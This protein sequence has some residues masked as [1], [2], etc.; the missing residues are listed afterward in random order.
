MI[1]RIMIDPNVRVR[2]NGTY[3]GFEDVRGPVSVGMDVQVYE[4]EAGI[5]GNGRVSEIDASRKLVF[6]SVD[7][8]SLSETGYATFD[9]DDTEAH[10]NPTAIGI[11]LVAVA[12]LGMVA[13]T[14]ASATTAHAIFEINL[15]IFEARE[16]EALKMGISA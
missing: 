15:G 14:W 4:P 2:G 12:A 11:S 5:F 16:R 3:A 1:T 13:P 10:R 6:L 9:D 8:E 7:W